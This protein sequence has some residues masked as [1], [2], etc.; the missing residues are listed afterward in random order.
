M[1]GID[2]NTYDISDDFS[3][4]CMCN[5]TKGS[6]RVLQ[7]KNL[8]QVELQHSDIELQQDSN[9]VKSIRLSKNNRGETTLYYE[10]GKGIYYLDKFEKNRKGNLLVNG[11]PNLYEVNNNGELIVINNA[12]N[13]NFD[14]SKWSPE[15]QQ[16]LI[17]VKID[18]TPKLLSCFEEYVMICYMQKDKLNSYYVGIYDLK[19][20]YKAYNTNQPFSFLPQIIPASSKIY[21][22]VQ[23]KPHSSSHDQE[24]DYEIKC[25][26]EFENA[27]KLERYF[28]KNVF[29]LAF[30]FAKNNKYD[31]NL[32]AEIS[33]YHA[34]HFYNKGDHENAIKHYIKTIGYIEPSYVIRK[35][36][37]VSHIQCLINYLEEL[38]NHKSNLANP[39]HTALLLNCFVKLKSTEKLKEWLTK[40]TIDPDKNK[41]YTET[42]VKVC[43]ELDQVD[44]AKELALK[45]KHHELYLQ[46]LI[47]NKGSS[48]LNLE[49]GEETDR[50]KNYFDAIEYIENHIN[51]KDQSKLIKQF[52]QILAKYHPR[53]MLEIIKKLI[54]KG[55]G[56]RSTDGSWDFWE[57]RPIIYFN[58]FQGSDKTEQTKDCQKQ[59]IEYY[60]KHFQAIPDNE[61]ILNIAFAFYLETLKDYN[62]VA[63]A[64]YRNTTSKAIEDIE[65][66]LLDMLKEP[67][68]EKKL[69][70][71][72]ILLLLKLYGFTDG[73]T[74]MC[75]KLDLKEEL[76]NYYLSVNKIEDA[77]TYC[78]AYG[79]GEPNQWITVLNY[80]CTSS[81]PN[82]E[83]ERLEA[84]DKVLKIVEKLENQPPMLIL[85]ILKNGK[86]IKL[87]HIKDYFKT[88]QERDQKQIKQV[89]N[90]FNK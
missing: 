29:D 43:L 61:Q 74:A 77:I 83:K 40:V 38:H 28:S 48:L 35:F 54:D 55:I 26:S 62:T 23:Q 6:L 52:G 37:D 89:T 45:C 49:N 20:E 2:Y 69:D 81:N 58:F 86:N 10:S 87:M 17:E 33:R 30:R 18:G 44:L 56:K 47:E 39:H 34:D 79:K 70:K 7:S 65:K 73:V 15:S 9:A 88:K 68:Y 53:K 51:E 8:S 21:V 75:K 84:I 76:V 63:H 72:H 59:L 12:N 16:P 11:P 5:Y 1:G 25:F 27:K 36:I 46:I 80:L 3:T 78:E 90:F 50:T 82:N 41:F 4:L 64:Q 66:K 85:K 67:I 31:D 13:G 22:A 60:L 71:N 57:P 14:L 24:G 42:A 19:N 32:L